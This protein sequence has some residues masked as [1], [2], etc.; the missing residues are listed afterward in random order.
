MFRG[1]LGTHTPRLDDKGRLV[2]PAKF[3]EGLAGGLVLT[4]G[5]DRCIWVWPAAEFAAYAERVDQ[6]S[7]SDPRVQAY[8]RV[9][10]SGASDDIPDRQGRITVPAHLR[11]YAGLDRDVVVAGKN[12][13]AEIWDA[14]AWDRYLRQQEDAYSGLTEEVFPGL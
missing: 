14:A 6:A 13:T 7:R 4:K 10:F 12:T 2:L 3:R 1:F 8:Q 5:Q 9:L 11:E